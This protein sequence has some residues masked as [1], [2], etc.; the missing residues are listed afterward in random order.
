MPSIKFET[1][2]TKSFN[3]KSICGFASKLSDRKLKLHNIK[4][5]KY[6]YKN[7]QQNKHNIHKKEYFKRSILRKQDR[8]FKE[9]LL[10]F[11]DNFE[12]QNI[13]VS[14]YGYYENETYS[15]DELD[16]YYNTFDDC[17]SIS[18]DATTVA[19]SHCQTMILDDMDIY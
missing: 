5:R 15:S 17:S 1:Q 9:K 6:N 7:K 11:T 8:K 4:S 19:Y 13:N 14:I 16:Y 18:S 2:S 10:Q 3:S 12:Y